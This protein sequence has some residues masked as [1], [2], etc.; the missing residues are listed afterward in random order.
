MLHD[1][2]YT[3]LTLKKMKTTCMMT[4]IMFSPYFSHLNFLLYSKLYYITT[5]KI[6]ETAALTIMLNNA[7]ILSSSF[8]KV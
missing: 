8:K 7:L 6:Y 5:R 4:I 3:K 1:V 2:D